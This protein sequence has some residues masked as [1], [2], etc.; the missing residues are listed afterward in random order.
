MKRE[1]SALTP[2]LDLVADV[3]IPPSGPWPAPSVL[4][5]AEDLVS[6]LRENEAAIL[7]AAVDL[8]NAP[9]SFRE[10]SAE[11][12]IR[13]IRDLEVRE[14][15]TFEA[16]RRCV[17]FGY[18]AQPAVIRLLQELGYDINETPQPNGYR[19]D[20]FTPEIVRNVDT[21]RPVWIP[22]DRIGMRLKTAS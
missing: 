5:L 3:L 15:L 12:R 16:L 10:A 7:R 1:H 13:R 14:P 20:P 2:T 8:L 9:Q 6:H 21:R 11:E 4:Q 18:Y 22:A 19:M 17:Y